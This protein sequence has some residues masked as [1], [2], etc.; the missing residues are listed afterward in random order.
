[1]VNTFLTDGKYYMTNGLV[2]SKTHGIYSSLKVLNNLQ[3]IYEVTLGFDTTSDYDEHHKELVDVAY[4]V[5]G[6]AKVL[7]KINIS[8][9]T[10]NRFEIKDNASL[11]CLSSKQYDFEFGYIE[12][13][14]H[15]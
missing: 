6:G 11:K 9:R 12:L 4:H 5:I 1:M 10:E 15:G 2:D 3:S 14:C 7:S 13:P 8:G